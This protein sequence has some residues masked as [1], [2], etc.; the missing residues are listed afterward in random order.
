M[1]LF[2]T[3]MLTDKLNKFIIQ[4]IYCMQTRLKYWIFTLWVLVVN[5][6]SEPV[7]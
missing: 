6:I 3:M 5:M 4:I 7:V 1:W 2:I